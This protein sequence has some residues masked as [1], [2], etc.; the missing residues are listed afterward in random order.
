MKKRSR[1][2]VVLALISAF[3]SSLPA[4]GAGLA[5]SMVLPRGNRE[6]DRYRLNDTPF[7]FKFVKRKKGESGATCFVVSN[8]DLERILSSPVGRGPRG[9]VRVSFEALKGTYFRQSD[10]VPLVR[11][12]YIGIFRS[13]TEAL[14]VVIESVAQWNRAQAFAWQ[15]KVTQNEH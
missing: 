6:A 5:G 13:T 7:Y 8:D 11:S 15:R 1:A 12:G 2:L 9:G 10:L 4:R 14:R 3:A